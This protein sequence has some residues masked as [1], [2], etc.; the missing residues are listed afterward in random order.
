MK[1]QNDTEP[2]NH[3]P[4]IEDLTITQTRAE[5]VKGGGG[6]SNPPWGIDRIDQRARI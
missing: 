5:E 2:D 6:V 3:Q 4:L 1:Q